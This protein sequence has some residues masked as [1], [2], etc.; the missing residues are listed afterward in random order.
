MGLRIVRK[1]ALRDVL[2]VA[3]KVGKAD[4]L[5]VEDPQKASRAAAV[6]DV[7]LAIGVDGGKKDA[8]LRL[9]DA[10][11]VGRDAGLPRAAFFHAC[12]AMARPFSSSELP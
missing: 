4:G 5:V 9:D 3:G 2:P 10:R 7:G 1:I 11:E 12:I 6:L 8:R